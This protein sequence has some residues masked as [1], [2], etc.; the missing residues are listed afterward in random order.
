MIALLERFDHQLFFAVNQGLSTPVLDYVFWAV[1]LVGYAGVLIPLA[2]IGLWWRDRQTF[3]QHFGWFILAVVTGAVL[4]QVLKY[5]FVRP[6]PL[7]EFAALLQAGEL[8]INVIG[9]NLKKFSFPS[10]HAQAVASVCTYLCALYPRCWLWWGT[11]IL[12]AGTARVYAGVHFPSDVVVGILIGS[13]SAVGALR[14]QRMWNILK[15]EGG[16][17]EAK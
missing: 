8:H 4:V 10:G 6:R 15:A 17:R 14:L 9:P 12:L 11:G 1:W 5:G 7:S 13:L 16:G 3:K 2:G